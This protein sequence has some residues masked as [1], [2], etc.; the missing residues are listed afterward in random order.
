[1]SLKLGKVAGIP[2]VLSS[3]L[4]YLVGIISLI[5]II[6]SGFMAGVN[7]VLGVS[8]LAL[9]VVLHELGHSLTALAFDART[10]IISLSFLGGAAQINSEDCYSLIS[11]P[12]K[13]M[14]VWMAG[15]A[16]SLGLWFSLSYLANFMTPGTYLADGIASLA[17]IN[18][19]LAIFNLMPVY[20]LDGGVILY[21]LMR[22]VFSKSIAIRITSVVGIIGSIAFIIAAFKYRAVI[23]G[24]IGVMAL[25]S[26]F[27]APKNKLFA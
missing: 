12:F 24:I 6:S 27:A 17:Q 11:K 10:E 7:V 25:L 5:N 22:F 1:M 16:V 14:L 18:L 23:L 13:A 26:S 15:P 4:L 8:F 2:I 3:D 19:V 20:P 21:C 9:F